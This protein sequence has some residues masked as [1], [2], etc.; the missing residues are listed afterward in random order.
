MGG[1]WRW[2][3]NL[4]RL[5]GQTS[6]RGHDK[7]QLQ[8][9]WKMVARILQI[10]EKSTWPPDG[11]DKGGRGKW[12][13]R[14]RSSSVETMGINAWLCHLFKTGLIKLRM[15]ESEQVGAGA[16]TRKKQSITRNE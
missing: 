14:Q 3:G 6:A 13:L 4:L 10:R 7:R 9:L 11:R 8:R 16:S 12:E 2:D 1:A 5:A 15:A